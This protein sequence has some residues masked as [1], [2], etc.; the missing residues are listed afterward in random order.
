MRL[1]LPE[2]HENA[3]LLAD[4]LAEIPGVEVKRDDVHINMV[5]FS[6]DREGDP[7]SKPLLDRGIKINAPE[8]GM[9]RMVTHYWIS[10][11]D[12]LKTAAAVSEILA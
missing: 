2:D 11:E 6:L 9:Y 10:R 4:E 1:R 12:I 7:L 5:F 8:Q 3:L